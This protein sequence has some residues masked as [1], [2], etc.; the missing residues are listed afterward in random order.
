MPEAD[1]SD[2]R[3][4]PKT[5]RLECQRS[6]QGPGLEICNPRQLMSSAIQASSN[7]VAS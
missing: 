5:M 7:P 3:A 1:G 4:Q 2:E 6:E